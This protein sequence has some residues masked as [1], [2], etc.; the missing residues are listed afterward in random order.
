[1]DGPEE[2]SSYA[3]WTPPAYHMGRSPRMVYST[4]LLEGHDDG[5]RNDS[6]VFARMAKWFDD[7][8]DTDL[9]TLLLTRALL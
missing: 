7:P 3:H 4:H 8:R 5:G 9:R 6:T 2:T 1:M